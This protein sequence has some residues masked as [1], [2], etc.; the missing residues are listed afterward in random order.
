MTDAAAPRTTTD[1]DSRE[2]ATTARRV[3]AT[4]ATGT[5]AAPAGA[6]LVTDA[7][8]PTPDAAAPATAAARTRVAVAPATAVV[9]RT[10]AAAGPG[11]VTGVTENPAPPVAGIAVVV[12]TMAVLRGIAV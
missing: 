6:G 7:T 3:A 12:R 10:I 9:A 8:A 11:P 1:H 5:A 4:E 2:D